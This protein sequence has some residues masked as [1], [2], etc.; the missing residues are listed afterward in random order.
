MTDVQTDT[1]SATVE[2][3]II[4]ASG[5]GPARLS[6]LEFLGSD[7][8]SELGEVLSKYLRAEVTSELDGFDYRP[9]AE[10]HA[11]CGDTTMRLTAELPPWPGEIS[12]GFD[13]R[14]ILTM[15]NALLG[16]QAGPDEN[17]D[18]QLSRLETRLIRQIAHSILNSLTSH[19]A[20]IRP[21]SVRNVEISEV[22]EDLPRWATAER[23]FTLKANMT[24]LRCAG[25]LTLVLPEDNLAEDRDLIAVVPEPDGDQ[26]NEWRTELSHLLRKADVTLTA[27]LAEAQITLAEAMSWQPGKTIAVGIDTSRELTVFCEDKTAFRAVAGHRDTG[28]IA[29]RLTTDVDMER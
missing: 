3:L 11:A 6:Y 2:D 5:G 25:A 14:L 7:F 10:I 13:R 4:S 24:L 18:R 19:L 28:A 20:A 22:G 29:L 26:E 15:L 8:A 9:G 17:D 16:Q 27:V 23:C 1:T 12:I 21:I